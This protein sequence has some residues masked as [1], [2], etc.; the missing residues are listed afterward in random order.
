MTHKHD[1]LLYQTKLLPL[2]RASLLIF[3]S[4]LILP[5]KIIKAEQANF[6]INATM[7]A[8]GQQMINLFPVLFHENSF[9]AIEN[10]NLIE[11]SIN[12]ILTLFENAEPH[13][14]SRTITFKTSFNVLNEH[15]KET[16]KAFASGKSQYAQQLLKEAVSICTSCHTQDKKQRTLFKETSRKS[17]ARDFEYA[18]FSFMTR[19]YGDAIKYYDDFLTAPHTQAS[20]NE[21]MTALKRELT[22]FAQVYNDPGQG[23]DHLREHLSKDKLTPYVVRNVT[24]WIKGLRELES[25]DVF[26]DNAK[27]F[28]SLETLVHEY[29]GPLDNPGASTVPSK[30]EVV[31]HVWLRGLLYT[32]LNKTPTQEEIPKILYWLSINDRA[33][34]YSYYYSLADL[35][36]QECMLIYTSNPYAKKCYEEYK[37][38]IEFSYSGSLGTEIPDDLQRELKELH[39]KVFGS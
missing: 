10:K 35:Y 39:K 20:E 12:N 37:E 8:I 2:L 26:I 15:L 23:A 6:D 31:F 29:L 4:L 19:N 21:M 11:N 25:S 27:D 7:T 18:E 34:N 1:N 30:R 3:L 33:T 38:Y 32:Y 9:K 5:A 36:L 22:I 16:Q 13:F 14:Q 28:A 17:F 24:E